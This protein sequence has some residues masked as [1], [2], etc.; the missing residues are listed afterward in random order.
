MKKIKLNIIILLKIFV[1]LNLFLP[2]T[3]NSLHHHSRLMVN[4]LEG[5]EYYMEKRLLIFNLEANKREKLER[6]IFSNLCEI[7]NRKLVVLF[8]EDKNHYNFITKEKDDFLKFNLP[9]VTSLI[10]LD[11]DL[12]YKSN[13]VEEFKIL[14]DLIDSM[15]MRKKQMVN[16]KKCD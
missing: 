2:V 10:G 11:G 13:S 7:E 1:L 8:K 3:I 9:F 4:L 12:K 14:F 16:D 15:P 5:T 6:Y